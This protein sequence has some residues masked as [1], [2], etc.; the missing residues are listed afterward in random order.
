[1][2]GFHTEP[3]GVFEGGFFSGRREPGTRFFLKLMVGYVF[4]LKKYMKVLEVRGS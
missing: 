1:M 4:N 3:L 2:T